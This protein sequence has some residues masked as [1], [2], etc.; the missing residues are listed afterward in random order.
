M[1]LHACVLGIDGSGKSTAVRGAAERLAQ[2]GC[3]VGIAGEAFAVLGDAETAS[4]PLVAPLAMRAKRVAKRLVDSRALYPP[5][6]LL[7]MLLQDSAAWRMGRRAAAD[8]V[9]SDG[10]LLL[11]AAGRAGNYRRAA[12][13]GEAARREAPRAEDLAALFATLCN[14]EPLPE[15]ARSRLP[16]LPLARPLFQAL[17]G[18]G[19]RPAWLPDVAIFLDIE[20][21]VALTRIE[22]RGAGRDLHENR[23]DLEQARAGYSRALDAFARHRGDEAVLTLDVTALDAPGVAGAIAT[24][25]KGRLAT[26]A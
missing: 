5:A 26:R 9:I 14:G 17:R 4:L 21:A 25:V 12:S 19:L 18:A 16:P 2:L 10:N 24:F 1:T 13:R 6:K 15:S 23:A 7:H 20:P 8:V 11:N 22:A 3:R